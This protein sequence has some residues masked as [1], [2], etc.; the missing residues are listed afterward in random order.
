[1]PERL[2]E[3]ILGLLAERKIAEA[4]EE[5]AFDNLPGAGRPLPEDDL[6]NLPD[7]VRLAYRILRMLDGGP[8][9]APPDSS[10][11][12]EKG[13]PPK[14]SLIEELELGSPSEARAYKNLD[15]LRARLRGKD[16]PDGEGHRILR[17]GYLDKVLER[18]YPEKRQEEEK[19][20]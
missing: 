20:E 18:L 4:M 5:G 2:V 11:A 10:A 3:N 15:S 12:S 8:E 14:R 16:G 9:G 6:A 17:S 7:D 13:A 19:K 1:V